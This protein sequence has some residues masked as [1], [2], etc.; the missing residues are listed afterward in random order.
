MAVG[1][2]I[3]R[4][5]CREERFGSIFRCFMFRHYHRR[6]SVQ[7]AMHWVAIVVGDVEEYEHC[8]LSASFCGG[9]I[10]R[11]RITPLHRHQPCILW[12]L[13]RVCRCNCCYPAHRLSCG[14][15][16]GTPFSTCEAMV[17]LKQFLHHQQTSFRIKLPHCLV[18]RLSQTAK[19]NIYILPNR[20]VFGGLRQNIKDEKP[21]KYLV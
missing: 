20:G 2:G 11:A 17:T 5:V 4:A 9:R 21:K 16:S 14:R 1:G 13:R 15:T 8:C 18:V 3:C 6:I 10:W 12:S 19:Y 7:L